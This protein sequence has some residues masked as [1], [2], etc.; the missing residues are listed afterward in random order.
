MTISVGFQLENLQKFRIFFFNESK[1]KFGKSTFEEVSWVENN[2][3]R[4]TFS[5][6]LLSELSRGEAF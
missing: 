2:K 3:R 5:V 6:R 1:K 4:K